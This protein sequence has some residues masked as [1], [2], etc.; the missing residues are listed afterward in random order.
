[1]GAARTCQRLVHTRD[2][3][4]SS[5]MTMRRDVDVDNPLSHKPAPPATARRGKNSPSR[6]RFRPPTPRTFGFRLRPSG[7]A[8][9]YS[10]SV[11]GARDNVTPPPV[12][13]KRRRGRTNAVCRHLCL[14]VSARPAGESPPRG[15]GRGTRRDS[16]PPRRQGASRRR[17]RATA[18]ACDH[19]RSTV[20]EGRGARRRPHARCG[21]LARSEPP[22]PPVERLP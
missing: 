4:S 5:E 6:W 3:V 7:A 22:E 13:G 16:R 2:R 9:A 20:A 18:D 19:Q 21:N 11:L 8:S 14:R 10:R 1:V 17:V 15:E 12:A